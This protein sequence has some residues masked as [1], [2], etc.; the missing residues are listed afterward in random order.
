LVVPVDPAAR[1]WDGPVFST[2]PEIGY[3]LAAMLIAIS[4]T[5]AFASS[6]TLMAR[7]APPG[8]A[9]E[10]FGLYALSNA[11]TAWLAPL[12]VEYFTRTYHSQQAGFAAIALLLLVG[13]ALLLRVTPPKRADAPG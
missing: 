8:M 6:R 2:A 11:A 13:L 10:L 12:M 9:G 7:L 1:I 4:I 5:A 3:L